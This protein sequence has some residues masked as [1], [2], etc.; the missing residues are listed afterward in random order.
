MKIHLLLIIV[1]VFSSSCNRNT[2]SYIP[3]MPNEP[4]FVKGGEVKIRS[5]FGLDHSEHQ[6]AVSPVRHLGL[7]GSLF[8]GYMGQWAYEYGGLGYIPVLPRAVSGLYFSAGASRSEGKIDTHYENDEFMY[9]ISRGSVKSYYTANHFQYSLYINNPKKG[10]QAGLL[11]K[12]SYIH[13]EQLYQSGSRSYL[14]NRKDI[15]FKGFSCMFFINADIGQ[16]PFYF[17]FQGGAQANSNPNLELT[18]DNST[19]NQTV[20]MAGYSVAVNMTMGLRF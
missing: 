16:S 15:L 17:S 1:A 8:T 3:L 5:G 14:S 18:V 7:T 11:A 19:L 4:A 12:H 13:F 2:Y 20:F 9:G 10:F 6:A